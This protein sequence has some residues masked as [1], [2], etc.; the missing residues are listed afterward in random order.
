[1]NWLDEVVKGGLK[2]ALK[3]KEIIAL[4]EG[5]I[6]KWWEAHKPVVVTPPILTPVP[7]PTPGP[8]PVTGQ[9]VIWDA[10]RIPSQMRARG[11]VGS[12]N[13]LLWALFSNEDGLGYGSHTWGYR[14]DQNED[15]IAQALYR[16]RGEI[17]TWFS[18]YVGTIGRQLKA[19]PTMTALVIAND[20]NDA[21]GC[22]M[23]GPI[24][25]QLRSMGVNPGQL[26]RGEIYYP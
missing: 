12:D 20:R 7:G 17:A 25:D 11:F 3:D 8:I 22:F 21:G 24:E 16:T 6:A 19:N 10:D 1:M 2:N 4:L 26:S 9:L 23:F 5:I 15:P 13:Q 18:D 14:G